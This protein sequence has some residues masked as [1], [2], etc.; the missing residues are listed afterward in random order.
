MAHVQAAHNGTYGR[1]MVGA[2]QAVWV[3]YGWSWRTHWVDFLTEFNVNP[4]VRRQ[5]VVQG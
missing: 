1:R 4:W 3:A 2:G 5:S